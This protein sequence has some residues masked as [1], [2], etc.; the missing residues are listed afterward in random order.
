MLL[1]LLW[2][3]CY[4]GKTFDTGHTGDTA[5]TSGASGGRVAD[6]MARALQEAVADNGGYGGGVLRAEDAGGAWFERAEGDR[7]HGGAPIQAGDSFEIASI[8]KTFTATTI[9]QLSE[10]GALSL[11][12]PFAEL[13]PEYGSD[14]LV[15]GGQ[16]RT[17]EITVR[18]L[19]QHTSG[20]P[21]Y[22]SDP[23]YLY[24]QVNA[25]LDAFLADPD[26]P[27]TPEMTLSYVP[28]LDPIH[29]P[30]GGWHYSDTNY[31]LLGLIIERLEG[32]VL[33]DAMRRRLFDPLGMSGTRMSFLEPGLPDAHR[34]EERWDM[35]DKPHQIADWAG[36]GLISTAPDLARFMRALAAGDLFSDPATLDQMRATVPTDTRDVSYGL[37]VL[38]VDIGGDALWGHDGYGSSFMYFYDF[39]GTVF[40]GTLDQTETDWW[41]LV[42]P[43]L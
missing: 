30:G 29:A 35:S 41:P 5:D 21:D 39:D 37:G 36:G 11:D 40:T 31:V 2:I 16:D 22:W 15:I 8:T 3:G 20:L 13:L 24:G 38:S 32:E 12:Q 7:T 25:F 4:G 14:L 42:A 18:Q 6:R 1:G 19:L 34:Y 28:D 43:A 33:H 10:E 9:L 17:G 23:P 27:W 26:Q